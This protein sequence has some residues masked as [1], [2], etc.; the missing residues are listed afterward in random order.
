MASH[1]LDVIFLTGIWF[2]FGWAVAVARING[3][4]WMSNIMSL[5]TKKNVCSFILLLLLH[6]LV[7]VRCVV[8]Q[9]R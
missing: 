7:F 8:S 6:A 2:G 1:K 9:R 5:E 4:E 3:D